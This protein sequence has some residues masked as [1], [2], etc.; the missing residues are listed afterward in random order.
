MQHNKKA[1]TL[2][3]NFNV[4]ARAFIT[5]KIIVINYLLYVPL[6]W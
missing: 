2:K 5:K 6:H 3:L 1:A 4:A